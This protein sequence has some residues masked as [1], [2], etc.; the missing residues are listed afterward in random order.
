MDRI[1][2]GV[3]KSWTQLS[4]F[5]FQSNFSPVCVCVF[6]TCFKSSG[7]CEQKS[8]LPL[9]PCPSASSPLLAPPTFPTSTPS[10]LAFP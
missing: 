1:V 3:T 10:A 7:P 9:P 2:H 5:H 4:N 8:V 6:L